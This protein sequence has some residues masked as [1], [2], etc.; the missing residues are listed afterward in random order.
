MVTIHFVENSALFES[1]LLL[2]GYP[3]ALAHDPL[4]RASAVFLYD[5]V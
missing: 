2:K 1:P 3:D 5:G 4:E